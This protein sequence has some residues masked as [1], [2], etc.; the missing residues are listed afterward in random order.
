MTN[1]H[2][3]RLPDFISIHA[4]GGPHFFTKIATTN[5]ARELR[6]CERDV[7]ICK[8]IVKN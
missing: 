7:A 2:N 4:S 1:Y 8:Y 3:V 6:L 5:S